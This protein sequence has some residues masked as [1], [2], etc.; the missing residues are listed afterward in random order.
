MKKKNKKKKRKEKQQI[1]QIT[2]KRV[3]S[4][5]TCDQCQKRKTKKITTKRWGLLP[6]RQTL[7]YLKATLRTTLTRKSK[8]PL[9]KRESAGEAEIG[10]RF[11]EFLSFSQKTRKTGMQQL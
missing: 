6:G 10:N 3:N 9:A 7:F 4:L 8:Q 5:P 11:W 2:I 1:E